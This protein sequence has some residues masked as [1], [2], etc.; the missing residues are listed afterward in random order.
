M[1]LASLATHARIVADARARH[2]WSRVRTAA[3]PVATAALAAG[4]AYL[5]GR[6]VLE[7][8][9]PFFAAFSA[10]ACLGFSFDRDLRRVGEIALGVTMGVTMGDLVVRSIGSGWWQI[11]L[12]LFMSA[13]LA[14]F[15]DRG[16]IFASQAGAQAIVVA[17]VPNLTGGPYGRALDA[18]T[19]GLVALIVAM[20]IP[21]DPRRALRT[22]MATASAALADTVAL[23]ASAIDAGDPTGAERAL[24][25]ARAADSAL[26][27][28]VEA[29]STASRQAQ[30]TVNR[31]YADDLAAAQRRATL[32]DQ[33]MRSVRVL[34]RRA[35]YDVDR[36]T[37]ADRAQIAALLTRFATGAREL[38]QALNSNQD[39]AAARVTMTG[40]AHDL[41]PSRVTAEPEA[42][43]QLMVLRSA[44]VDTL[45]AT[46]VS[47]QAA[48]APLPEY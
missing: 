5:I 40:V 25:R 4:I 48:R 1:N 37:A 29:A 13:L 22:T 8:D 35:M 21:G 41:D 47:P 32:L 38:T 16:A 44:V 36:V 33:A 2:G 28:A 14:R 11:A 3:V 15:V 19:G 7:H 18:I 9:A 45:E 42:Q 30:L 24:L 43:T 27:E 17:G 26:Q 39:A 20:L 31:R 23:L 10:W 12:V 6:Y 46:G 34:A